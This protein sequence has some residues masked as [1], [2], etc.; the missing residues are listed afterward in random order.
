[1]TFFVIVDKYN[2]KTSQ[3]ISGNE[4]REYLFSLAMTEI[5]T[6][7]IQNCTENESALH[8]ITTT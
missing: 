3:T 7:L 2:I 5:R 1:M 4:M 6:E 8:L